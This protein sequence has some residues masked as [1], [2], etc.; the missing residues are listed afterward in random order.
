[1]SARRQVSRDRGPADLVD[2]EPTSRLAAI[3]EEEDDA[4]IDDEGA[5]AL[6]V[7]IDDVYTRTPLPG[8]VSR[9]SAGGVGVGGSAV[10]ARSPVD[11]G[12][13]GLLSRTP[14]AVRRLTAAAAAHTQEATD[15]YSRRRRAE[16]AGEGGALDNGASR[17]RSFPS[18][19][20]PHPPGQGDLAVG[21][22]ITAGAAAAAASAE[23]A[24]SSFSGGGSL[25]LLQH[26]STRVEL[27]RQDASLD[28]MSHQL[29]RLGEVAIAI[30]GELEDQDRLI[31]QVGV[32]VEAADASVTSAER[33]IKKLIAR[34][35]GAGYASIL[36]ALTLVLLLLAWI[37]L[38]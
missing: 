25:P 36:C 16:A 32:E 2:A 27:A 11:V 19:I 7:P 15:E 3:G 4:R 12:P 6:L 17:P 13:G 14:D 9:S 22:A 5:P 35:G 28:T 37:A 8:R 34:S 29:G 1:M 33:E 10:T 38:T 21:R 20:P 30:G 23:A 31:T 24:Q 18:A 26:H